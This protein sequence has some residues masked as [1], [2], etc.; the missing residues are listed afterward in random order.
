MGN[1]RA[2]GLHKR[3]RFAP[4]LFALL[5]LFCALWLYHILFPEETAPPGSD[6]PL[7]ASADNLLKLFEDECLKEVHREWLRTRIR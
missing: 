7:T 3:W 4:V 6:R 2:D 5:F 1:Q